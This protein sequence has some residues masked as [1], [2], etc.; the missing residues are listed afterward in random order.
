[1]LIHTHK[2]MSCLLFFFEELMWD[3]VDSNFLSPQERINTA[4]PGSATTDSPNSE[5]ERQ[6]CVVI[7]RQR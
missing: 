7:G 1:M 5:V 2:T 4:D 6:M 3:Q